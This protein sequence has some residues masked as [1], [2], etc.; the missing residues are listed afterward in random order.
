MWI[1]CEA[2][3]ISSGYSTGPV[4]GT[5]LGLP[6]ICTTAS[7]RS[8]GGQIK[9]NLVEGFSGTKGATATAAVPALVSVVVPAI[10]VGVLSVGVTGLEDISSKPTKTPAIASA[11]TPKPSAIHKRRLPAFFFPWCFRLEA[12]SGVRFGATP[13]SPG[14]ATA[15]EPG[16]FGGLVGLR[17]RDGRGLG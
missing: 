3:R 10:V 5:F 14:T 4:G 1:V 7:D 12:V 13:S 8:S 11:A 16:L 17:L 6:S 15:S 9:T 2:S